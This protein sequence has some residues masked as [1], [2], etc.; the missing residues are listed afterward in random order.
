MKFSATSLGVVLLGLAGIACWGFPT[1]DSKPAQ[2]ENQTE[3]VAVDPDLDE[4][5][6][7]QGRVAK[8]EGRDLTVKIEGELEKFDVSADADIRKDR[9]RAKLSELAPRDFVTIVTVGGG[10]RE[11]V[12]KVRAFSVR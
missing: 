4:A 1:F 2:A 11:K 5:Q 12:K 3:F 9:K 8:V 7:W 6:I 10:D